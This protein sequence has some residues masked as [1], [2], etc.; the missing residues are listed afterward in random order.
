MAANSS[1]MRRRARSTHSKREA[2]IVDLMAQAEGAGKALRVLSKVVADTM[3]E[4]H[5]RKF[6]VCI[7]HDTPMI[8]IRLD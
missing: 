1:T 2:I 7:D 4:V 6:R 3:E 5:G 8:L